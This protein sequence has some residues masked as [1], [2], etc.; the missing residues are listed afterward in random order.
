MALVTALAF[1][2]GKAVVLELLAVT[3]LLVAVG[4]AAEEEVEERRSSPDPHHGQLH[5]PVV[6]H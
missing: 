4:Q 5:P 3:M 1:A 6:D 2:V